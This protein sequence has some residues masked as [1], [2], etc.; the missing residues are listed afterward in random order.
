MKALILSN[1]S[2][3]IAELNALTAPNKLA[4]GIAIDTA[5]SRGL[6]QDKGNS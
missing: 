5:L 3:A 6:A 2:D 1:F 4:T